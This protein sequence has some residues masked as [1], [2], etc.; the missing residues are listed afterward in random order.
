MTVYYEAQ[1]DNFKNET[2]AFQQGL[3]T[4]NLYIV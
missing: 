1:T 2:E 3:L 4:I